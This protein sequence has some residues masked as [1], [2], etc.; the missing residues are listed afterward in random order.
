MVVLLIFIAAIFHGALSLQC[1][2]CHGRGDCKE[3]TQCSLDTQFCQIL[4]CKGTG[5][6]RD[7]TLK[8]CS[9]RITGILLMQIEAAGCLVMRVNIENTITD[10]AVCSCKEDLCNNEIMY[11]K[12]LKLYD[13]QIEKP[14]GPH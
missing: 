5:R 7:A 1:H 3:N 4:K 13:E 11:E 6:G 14:T 12:T 2:S 8:K 9:D 10:C